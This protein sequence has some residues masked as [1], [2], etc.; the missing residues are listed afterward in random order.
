MKSRRTA[1]VTVSKWGN[2]LAIRLAA[3]SAQ[4]IG[5]REG[6]TLRAE[7]SNGRLILAPE[8]RTV[9]EAAARKLRQ[10]IDSQVETPAVVSRMRRESRY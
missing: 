6:D 10:F 8:K 4:A 3:E 5:V 9:D 7:I 1:E 2:S